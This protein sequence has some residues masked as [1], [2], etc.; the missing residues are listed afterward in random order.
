MPVFSSSRERRGINLF[1]LIACLIAVAG[2]MWIGAN[3]LGVDLQGAAYTALDETELLEK[4][5][6][7]WRPKN[8]DCPEGDC[9]DPVEQRATDLLHARTQLESLRN[10]V[11]HMGER[12]TLTMKAEAENVK[13]T[14]DQ[15][16]IRGQTVSYWRT[17]GEIVDAVNSIL[18]RL[19]EKAGRVD[20]AQSLAARRQ[21][22]DYGVRAIESLDEEG[23]DP[24]AIDAAK[25]ISEWLEMG[26]EILD[27]A[28]V[29]QSPQPVGGRA[30]S[31]EQHLLRGE[32]EYGKRTEFVRRKVLESSVMLRSRYLTEFPVLAL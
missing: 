27:R 20:A 31:P 18:E 32:T 30:V 2:G 7:E 26:V 8:P 13:L 22:I 5:P 19:D 1:E 16:V 9:P 12:G 11:E 15:L 14:D 10:E 28:A 17:L 6:E 25:R 4:V 24:I 23:V 3:Y 29:A 21:A